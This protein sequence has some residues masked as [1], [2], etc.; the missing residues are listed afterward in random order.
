M[1]NSGTIDAAN[2]TLADSLPASLS[3]V[4]ASVSQGHVQPGQMGTTVTAFLGTIP[5]G[6]TATMTIVTLTSNASIGTITDTATAS[7]GGADSVSTTVSAK[8]AASADLSVAL[9]A[10]PGPVLA[11]GLLTD[12]IIVTNAGPGT[13]SN[14]T[15]TL[16]L[17]AGVSFVSSGPGTPSVTNSGGSLVVNVG[18]MAANATATLVLI[19]EPTLAGTLTQTVSV[20][21]DSVDPNAANNASSA[22]TQVVPA[23]DL[24]VSVT[25]SASKADTIDDFTYTVSVTNHGPQDATGVVLDDTLP[26]GVTIIALSSAGYGDPTQGG[27]TVSL[28]VGS[29]AAGATATMTIE[30]APTVAPGSTLVDTASANAEEPDP[31]SGNNMASLDT[32]VL[33]VSDLGITASAPAGPIFVGQNV[34]Y[35]LTVT[36]HGPDLEPDASVSCPMSS[37]VAFGSAT[38]PAGGQGSVDDGVLTYDLGPLASG[39]TATV[40]VVLVPQ[41]SAAGSLAAS[42]AVA[43]EYLDQDQTNNDADTSVTV[44]PAADLAVTISTPATA[45]ALQVGWT[46]TLNVGNLGLSPASDVSVAAPLPPNVQIVSVSCSQGSYQIAPDGTVTADLGG[47]A[48]DHAAR[49]AIEVMPTAVGDFTTFGVGQ[50]PGA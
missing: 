13:A 19:V 20:T 4:S 5:A 15:A 40:L 50:R 9:S 30:I 11:G 39:A 12:T 21:G 14:V 26:S 34:T 1:T 41:A 37:S 17:A 18:T 2:V 33:G 8:V 49:V 36:N 42:F 35:T 46:Y 16:P 6:G 23:A 32:A 24:A 31:D 47:L 10:T 7:S 29:L 44:T 22:S 27:G 43:G 38:S 48:A 45:P 25:G 28:T 3:L